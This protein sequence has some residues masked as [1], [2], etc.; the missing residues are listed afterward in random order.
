MGRLLCGSEDRGPLGKAFSDL[1]QTEEGKRF[2]EMFCESIRPQRMCT[3]PPAES[4]LPKKGANTTRIAVPYENGTIRPSFGGVQE[5]KIYDVADKKI[6]A[7]KVIDNGRTIHADLVCFLASNETDVVI[8]QNIGSNGYDFFL[9]NH[10]KIYI[11][12]SGPADQAVQSFLDGTL[13]LSAEPSGCGNGCGSSDSL[14]DRR[15][16]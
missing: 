4:G 1:L 10:I 8:C 2:R 5:F 12:A 11:G 3:D 15:D 7:E 9:K 6:V 14:P 13:D 16:V